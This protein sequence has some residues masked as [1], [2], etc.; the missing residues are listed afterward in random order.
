MSDVEVNALFAAAFHLGIDRAGDNVARG[1]FLLGVVELH[2]AAAAGVDEDA[3]LA[4]HGF[5]DEEGF[6]RGVVEAGRV[7]LDELHVRN[8]R[9][10]APGH[11]H[12]VAGGH[13]GIG[14]VEINLPATAGGED[15]DRRAEGFDRSGG[16][17]E[18]IGADDAVFHGVAEL[19][20]GDEIDGHVVRHGFDGRVGGDF[21]QQCALDF[22]SGGVLKMQDAA[23]RVAALAAEVELLPAVAVFAVIEVDAEFHEFGNAGGSLGDD[24]ANDIRVAKP[25]SG[26]EGVADVEFERILV[27]HHAGNPALGPSG[28]G[29][30]RS[31]LGD[32]RDTA[33]VG[34][35]Q[36]E[37]ESGDAAA[38]DDE[39]EVAHFLGGEFP[40]REGN[41]VDESGATQVDRGAKASGFFAVG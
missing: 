38:E 15:S 25:G 29:V 21:F 31:A 3:A 36:S 19:A 22:A 40:G 13:I 27:A 39:I 14:R 4:A 37:R 35:L 23:L 33:L 17:I 11:R 8:G 41:V 34:G 16:L 5:G 30:R 7:K 18:D 1:E 12:A 6:Y 20:G 10:G 24:G 9:A 26:L 32:K 2:E 28:V